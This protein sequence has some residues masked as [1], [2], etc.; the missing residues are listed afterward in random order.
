[1]VA[2]VFLGFCSDVFVFVCV[3]LCCGW[4]VAEVAGYSGFPMGFFFF[5]SFCCD[6][7]F[8]FFFLY[9]FLFRGDFGEQWA[10]GSGGLGFSGFLF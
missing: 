8:F 5:F 9:G 6:A 2:W 4:V 10:V 3:W 7:G 1:M